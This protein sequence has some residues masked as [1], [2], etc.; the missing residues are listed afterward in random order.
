MIPAL[1][2]KS[3]IEGCNSASESHC[4]RESL[5]LKIDEKEDMS[6]TKDLSCASLFLLLI[7]FKVYHKSRK[8]FV[9]QKKERTYLI[10]R[11]KKTLL[12]PMCLNLSLWK[13]IFSYQ[14]F[15]TSIFKQKL[16][17]TKPKGDSPNDSLFPFLCRM[18]NMFLIF[19][20]KSLLIKTSLGDRSSLCLHVL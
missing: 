10:Q 8:W 7:S 2:T 20:S 9:H 3:W 17:R 6:T 18:V 19:L 13:T 15:A 5:K 12:H 1:F 16:T 11:K 14:V 4:S